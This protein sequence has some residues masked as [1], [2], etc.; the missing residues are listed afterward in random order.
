MELSDKKGF[1]YTISEEELAAHQLRTTEERI[2]WVWQSMLLMRAVQT[3]EER[4]MM[5][6]AKWDKNIEYYHR[7]GFPENI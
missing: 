5:L 6:E 4:I 7:F 1:H 3:R 2:E